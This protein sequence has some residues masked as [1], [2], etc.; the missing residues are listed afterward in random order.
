MPASSPADLSTAFRSFGRRIRQALEMADDDKGRLAAAAPHAA[1]L[2]AIVLEAAGVIGGGFG[3]SVDQVGP[4]IADHIDKISPDA[5]DETKLDQLRALASAAG[6]E[7]RS[8]E[9]AAQG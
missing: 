6:T 5:W 9:K 7:I 1:R 2:Q 3:T 8:A 4:A